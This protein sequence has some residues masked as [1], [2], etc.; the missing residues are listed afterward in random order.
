MSA[1]TLSI[2][3]QFLSPYYGW[4]QE[5][6]QRF[7][8]EWKAQVH[9]AH[10][11]PPSF[12][13]LPE[14]EKKDDVGVV[15]PCVDSGNHS[16]GSIHT[17]FKVTEEEHSMVIK[18]KKKKNSHPGRTQEGTSWSEGK[19]TVCWSGW[20]IMGRQLRQTF[21]FLSV[22]LY[23]QRIGLRSPRYLKTPTLPNDREALFSPVCTD[24]R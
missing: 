19:R 6:N 2:Q 12:S 15:R 24:A 13:H 11:K 3:L 21:Y 18:I 1:L 9:P 4:W 23:P 14:K 8:W 10:S 20:Q 16:H 22:P 17:K 7:S 5:W